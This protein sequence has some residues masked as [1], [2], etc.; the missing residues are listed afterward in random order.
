V[1][2]YPGMREKRATTV[3]VKGTDWGL[4]SAL[5]RTLA[6]ALGE[7]AVVRI[8]DPEPK[9]AGDIVVTT[10]T[11]SSLTEVSDLAE[12]GDH[13]IVLAALPDDAAEAG[14]RRAGARAYLPMV[15]AAAPLVA[16]VAGLVTSLAEAL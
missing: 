14:Y 6:S 9:E 2:D 11:A 1:L 12:K 8:G 16:A 4:E 3:Y 15:V 10:D 13:V 7:S 5:T